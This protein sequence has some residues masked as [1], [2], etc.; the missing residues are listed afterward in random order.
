LSRAPLPLR[1]LSLPLPPIFFHPCLRL[2]SAPRCES[3][4]PRFSAP[5]FVPFGWPN[6]QHSSCRTSLDHAFLLSFPP[7]FPCFYFFLFLILLRLISLAG[8]LSTTLVGLFCSGF[9][10]FFPFY[11]RSF[12]IFLPTPP[13][14]VFMFSTFLSLFI[15]YPCFESIV[16]SPG[17]ILSP[18]L[19]FVPYAFRF[20]VLPR[21]Y[22]A[23]LHS[24]CKFGLQ[25]LARFSPFITFFLPPSSHTHLIVF[26]PPPFSL[27]FTF[28]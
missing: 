27:I 4:L 24:S 28:F 19:L 6:N 23:T 8:S 9:S 11:I 14:P 1:Q 22:S 26:L 16:T 10:F 21:E 15:P 13:H 3:Q 18:A 20:D 17:S 12:C 25:F 2:F 7:F 5:W